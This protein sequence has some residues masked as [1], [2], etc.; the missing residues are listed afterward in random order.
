MMESSPPEDV[1][2]S[3]ST[4]TIKLTFSAPHSKFTQQSIQCNLYLCILND[5]NCIPYDGTVST[6]RDVAILLILSHIFLNISGCVK[7]SRIKYRIGSFICAAH[8]FRFTARVLRGTGVLVFSSLLRAQ[9]PGRGDF[10]R[11]VPQRL[12]GRLHRPVQ[13]QKPL[14]PRPAIQCQPQLHHRTH[15]QAHRQR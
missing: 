7:V 13:Q 14:L 8:L 1:K 4:E 9:Q 5:K 12:G 10:P 3:N 2:P 15:T 6:N 11:I